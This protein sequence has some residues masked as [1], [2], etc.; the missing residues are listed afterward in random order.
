MQ[1]LTWSAS[2]ALPAALSAPPPAP[3]PY[4]RASTA[5]TTTTEA[6][7]AIVTFRSCADPADRYVDVVFQGVP[8]VRS[9][10][11]SSVQ[12]VHEPGAGWTV[13]FFCRPHRFRSTTDAE[14]WLQALVTQGVML[15]DADRRPL[16]A[17]LLLATSAAW[18]SLDG[19]CVKP[20][21]SLEDGKRWVLANV[22]WL[23]SLADL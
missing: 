14:L 12:L 10:L 8:G 19:L 16:A 20:V 1:T 7:D 11:P 21:A 9:E 6:R 22:H 17:T 13:Q 5:A 4:G 15:F 3:S 23:M 2:D 18:S